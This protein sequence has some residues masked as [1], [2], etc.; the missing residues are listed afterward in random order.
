[1]VKQFNIDLGKGKRTE[2]E[3]EAGIWRVFQNLTFG[4]KLYALKFSSMLHVLI[5]RYSNS[6]ICLQF[7]E[8]MFAYWLWS[9]LNGESFH[10]R[11]IF[12]LITKIITGWFDLHI[13]EQHYDDITIFFPSE[14]SV[15][16]G[17]F[18]D[19]SFLKYLLRL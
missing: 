3:N 11:G 14:N 13:I 8:F 15:K 2:V 6:G 19:C 5:S 17:L 4:F 18:E 12:L 16:C 9:S 1:M 7:P 10:I